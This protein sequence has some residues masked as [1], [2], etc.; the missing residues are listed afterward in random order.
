MKLFFPA[1]KS[2]PFL[3]ML[4]C[5]LVF[6]G[7]QNTRANEPQEINPEIIAIHLMQPALSDAH[8]LDAIDWQVG[9]RLEYTI[10]AGRF[11]TVGKMEKEVSREI[12]D[13][14]WVDTKMEL[15]GKQELIETLIN[16]LDGKILKM[17][18]NGKEVEIPNQE[19]TIIDR[20][21]EKVKVPAGEF[22]AMHVIAKSEQVE[23]IEVWTNA[24]KTAMDGTLKQIMSTSLFDLT[25]ELTGFVRTR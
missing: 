19:I 1:W 17:L 6:G 22:E 18:R 20:K 2:V 16:R 14:I 8:I 9:D 21:I 13:A 11:G 7:L 12:A 4:S 3:S 23:R 15:S 10:S 24:D 5:F 25:F